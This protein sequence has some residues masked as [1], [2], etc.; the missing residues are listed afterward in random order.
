MSLEYHQASEHSWCTDYAHRA[1]ESAKGPDSLSV[2]RALLA[3]E[4]SVVQEA[5][6]RLGLSTVNLRAQLKA[7]KK[8]LGEALNSETWIVEKATRR[9]KE[10]GFPLA[11]DHLLEVIWDEDCAASRWLSLLIDAD[12]LEAA[13]NDS[14]YAELDPGMDVPW[15]LR[16][17]PEVSGPGQALDHPSS[18]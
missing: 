6:V 14:R 11:T 1:M 8:E 2:L 3:Q 16:P 10:E 5:F 4:G 15:G 12:R 18:H 17:G 9:A 13:L 7:H